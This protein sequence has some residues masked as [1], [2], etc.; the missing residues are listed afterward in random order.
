MLGARKEFAEM[1]LLVA[2]VVSKASK[3]GESLCCVVL[4]ECLL[5]S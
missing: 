4:A 5:E 3:E 2:G 1:F